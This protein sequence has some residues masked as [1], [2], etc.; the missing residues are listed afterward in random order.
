M[1][2]HCGERGAWRLI[3]RET[4]RRKRSVSMF[5]KESIVMVVTEVRK[6]LGSRSRLVFEN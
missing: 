1:N 2:Q 3:F 4:A 6:R 5:G